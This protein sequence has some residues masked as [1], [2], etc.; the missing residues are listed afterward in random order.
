M[1]NIFIRTLRSKGK[2]G[3]SIKF[4]RIVLSVKGN[5]EYQFICRFRSSRIG[6]S[7]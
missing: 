3:F 4:F 1:E 6:K 2:F 5:I 7:R